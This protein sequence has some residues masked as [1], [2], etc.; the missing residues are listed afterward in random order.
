ML[1]PAVEKLPGSRLLEGGF[2]VIG[3]AIAFPRSHNAGVDNLRIFIENLR[4]SDWM[5]QAI[6]RHGIH[7]LSVTPKAPPRSHA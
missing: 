6:E 7:G 4:A 2:T 1:F 3:Q 5:I